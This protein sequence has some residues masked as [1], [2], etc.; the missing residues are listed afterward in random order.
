MWRLP[1][2]QDLC[3]FP[4]PIKLDRSHET[5]FPFS[6][7]RAYKIPLTGRLKHANC[8]SSDCT[9]LRKWRRFLLLL[10]VIGI[11]G[12]NWK[13]H[14]KRLRCSSRVYTLMRLPEGEGGRA[15]S[16]F[17]TCRCKKPCRERPCLETNHRFPSFGSKSAHLSAVAHFGGLLLACCREEW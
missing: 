15:I 11:S 9:P 7:K 5:P 10:G 12:E 6:R 2:R 14:A 16:Q 8:F 13:T 3:G 1:K 4:I 17:T